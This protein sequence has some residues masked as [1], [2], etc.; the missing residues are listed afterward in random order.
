MLL[1]ADEPFARICEYAGLFFF[2]SAGNFSRNDKL[3]DDSRILLPEPKDPVFHYDCCIAGCCSA[4]VPDFHRA[5]HIVF[6]FKHRRYNLGISGPSRNQANNIN[7]Q[8]RKKNGADQGGKNIGMLR[9][10][11]R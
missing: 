10:K 5:V 6:A 9:K 1:K 11:H 7:N 3:P 8:Q 2:P 4:P